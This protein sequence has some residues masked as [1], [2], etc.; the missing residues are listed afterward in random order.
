MVIDRLICPVDG[1][2]KLIVIEPLPS[3]PIE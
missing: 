3:W 1:A 2:L